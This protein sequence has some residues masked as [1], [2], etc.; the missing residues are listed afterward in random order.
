MSADQPGFASPDSGLQ[1]HYEKIASSY[2][3][4]SDGG[5]GSLVVP[6]GNAGQP[7]HR[8]FHLK[9]AFSH[10]ILAQV[11]KDTGLA[12]DSNLRIFEPFAGSGTSGVSLAQLVEA[13]QVQNAF[14]QGLEANP[15]IHRLAATKIRALQEPPAGLQQVAEKV[16][17]HAAT[18]DRSELKTPNLSTFNG[19]LFPPGAVLELVAIREAIML[20]DL[21]EVESSLLQVALA[22]TVEPA[23][24]LRKDGRALRRVEYARTAD[25][26]LWFRGVV[27]KMDDDLVTTHREFNGSVALGDIRKFDHADSLVGTYDLAIF[28]PPY[29][30]NIDYTEVYKLEAWL[31]ELIKDRSQFSDQRHTSL[32]SHA[33]LKWDE[34]YAYESSP[35]KNEVQQLITP[36]LDAIPSDRY[37]RSRRQLVKGYTDDM[38]ISLMKVAESLRPDGKMVCVVGNSLHGSTNDN[39]LIAADLIICRLAEMVGLRIDHID[40]AR[41]PTRRRT[42]SRFLRE[43]AIFATKVSHSLHEPISSR[44]SGADRIPK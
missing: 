34:T 12:T 42:E 35:L 22:A 26:P 44:I 30:N 5:Y 17:A 1:T 19:S 8:W 36:L 10:Q 25:I 18:I 21:S 43:S 2:L 29:P 4:K 32:R 31:L 23:S 13:G 20:T 28:S 37:A 39:L 16:L 41:V 24:L 27:A 33:S 7:I 38:L 15:F 11:I 40:V 3:E 6:T 14:Y 9:E